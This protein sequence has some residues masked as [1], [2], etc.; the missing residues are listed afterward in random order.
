MDVTPHL[1]LASQALQQQIDVR[2]GT[3]VLNGAA[4][5]QQTIEFGAGLGSEVRRSSLA[6][7]SGSGVLAK[8]C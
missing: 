3:L 4:G 6:E 7:I 1:S 2:G 8:K 5:F